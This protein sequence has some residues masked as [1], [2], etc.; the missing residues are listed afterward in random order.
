MAAGITSDV[1]WEFVYARLTGDATLTAAMAAMN[2]SS[3]TYLYREKA[4]A[5]PTVYIVAH[6]LGGNELHAVGH[7][8]VMSDPL[9]RLMTWGRNKSP[10]Q[11]RVIRAR[12]AVLLDGKSGT[13]A[14]GRVMSCTLQTELPSLWE[15][16]GE[17][18]LW[19]PGLEFRVQAQ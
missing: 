11:T 1:V 18:T 3:A 7:I 14:S 17:D 2:G 8:H 9:L 12:Q 10:S 4:N 5:A 19:Y 13:T 16:D 6:I 15:L